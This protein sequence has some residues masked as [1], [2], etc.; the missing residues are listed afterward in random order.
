MPSMML[1]TQTRQANPR[2]PAQ[3]TALI[4]AGQDWVQQSGIRH[5]AIIMDGNRRWARKHLLPAVAGHAKGVDALKTMLRHCSDVGLEALTVFAFSTE[6]WRREATEVDAI[7]GLFIKALSQEIHQLHD[8]G[9]VLRFIGGLDALPQDLQTL[10]HDSMALTANN[11]GIHF[12][13]AVNY[14]GRAELVQATQTIAQQVKAGLLDPDAIDETA[15]SQ[16]LTTVGLPDP[17]MLIRT[18]GESRISNYL[19]WQCAYA[20]LY[21]SDLFWP[22]FSPE[23]MNQALA[24][25][26]SRQRRYGQ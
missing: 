2:Q 23:A 11:Q 26:A 25:F 18:G 13:V 5:V 4:A 24:T 3:P 19:L 1:S 9:V 12:Q 20:E 17:D 14:G 22:E 10:M 15:L 7:M 6:N 16:A 8:E 21:W